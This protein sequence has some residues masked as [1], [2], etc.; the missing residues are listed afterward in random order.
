M[1]PFLLASIL[2][3]ILGVLALTYQ[4]ITYTTSEKALDLGPLQ[5][6][7]ER[8]HTIPVAPILGV[9]AVVGGVV[10]FFAARRTS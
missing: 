1:K 7:T 6:T 3:I 2:L 8:T 9:L 5:I 4:G 10:M